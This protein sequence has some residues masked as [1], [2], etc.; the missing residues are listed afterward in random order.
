M[1]SIHTDGNNQSTMIELINSKDIIKNPI[2]GDGKFFKALNKNY[3]LCGKHKIPIIFT[4]NDEVL[5]GAT[6]ISIA[7]DYSE[8]KKI[9]K[10]IQ[11]YDVIP[12]K[13]IKAKSKP[14]HEHPNKLYL[15]EA[16]LY[17][18][19]IKSKKPAAKK[20]SIWITH[21]VLPNLRKYGTYKLVRSYQNTLNELNDEVRKLKKINHHLVNKS[22]S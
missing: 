11:S 7:L 18:L 3:I 14:K 15:T 17:S 13:H 16:G 1:G 20:F 21:E 10:C 8:P 5:F 22:E 19:M 12:L 2:L 6:E 4:D 9:K